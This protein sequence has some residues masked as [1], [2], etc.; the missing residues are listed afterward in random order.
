MHCLVG[1][2]AGTASMQMGETKA[3]V[4]VRMQCQAASGGYG[5]SCKS[6]ISGFPGGGSS[7]ETDLFGYDPAKKQYHWFAVTSMGETHDH[8]AELPTGPSI[9]FVYKGLQD[10]QPMV[11]AIKLTF[12]EDGKR[13]ELRNDGTI[14][15]KPAWQMIGSASKK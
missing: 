14:G 6:S 11:E 5:V 13:M 15:G 2:W 4:S 8:V 7:E 10:G 9:D 1:T 12:S 3:Q